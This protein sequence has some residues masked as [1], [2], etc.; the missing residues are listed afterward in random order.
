MFRV[1]I[2]FKL[3]FEITKCVKWSWTSVGIKI[4]L[5]CAWYR[6]APFLDEILKSQSLLTSYDHA[7][8][9]VQVFVNDAILLVFLFVVVWFFKLCSPPNYFNR[10]LFEVD[11]FSKIKRWFP[12]QS[13]R[14]FP[15]AMFS[16][17]HLLHTVVFTTLPRTGL[18]KVLPK[19]SHFF[20]GK[21]K[22]FWVRFLMSSCVVFSR[23]FFFSK[24]SRLF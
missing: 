20:I 24:K 9:L 6:R 11:Y 1:Y 13:I 18:E 22:L 8:T 19:I 23:N 15:W 21:I 17:T 5:D 14:D 16:Y 7:C 12:F 4:V 3:L 2:L 10:R